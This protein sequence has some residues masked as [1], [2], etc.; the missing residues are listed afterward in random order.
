MAVVLS[1]PLN[2]AEDNAGVTAETNTLPIPF[3]IAQMY[4]ALA[5]MVSSVEMVLKVDPNNIIHEPGMDNSFCIV[6]LQRR[7]PNF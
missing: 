3:N 7:L 5:K 2:H 1:L 6:N 4:A